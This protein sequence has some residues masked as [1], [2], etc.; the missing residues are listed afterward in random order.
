MRI[1]ADEIRAKSMMLLTSWR[2][3]LEERRSSSRTQ[4]KTLRKSKMLIF[5]LGQAPADS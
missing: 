2:I 5:S 4:E 1:P 3:I